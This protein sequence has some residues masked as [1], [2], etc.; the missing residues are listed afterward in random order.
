MSNPAAPPIGPF[1]LTMLPTD[2]GNDYYNLQPADAGS[3]VTNNPDVAYVE[4]NDDE[5]PF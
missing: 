2:K 5:I 4:V 3:N 1:V